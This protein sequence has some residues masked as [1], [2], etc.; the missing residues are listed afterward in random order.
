MLFVCLIVL[1]V[2]CC[3][4]FLFP[5]LEVTSAC[6]LELDLNLRGPRLFVRLED[7]M[8]PKVFGGRMFAF[9]VRN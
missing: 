6:S 9:Y 7:C 4:L 5:K 3:V 2:L 1:C 8:E